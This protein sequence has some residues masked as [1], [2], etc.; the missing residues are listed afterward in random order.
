MFPVK[1]NLLPTVSRFFDDDWNSLFDWSNRNFS[2]VQSTLPSVNIVESAEEFIVEMAA[3]GMKKEDFHIELNNNVLSISCE[4][5]NEKKEK[6]DENY[7]RREFSYQNFQR[8][9]NLNHRVVDDARINAIYKDGIL[10]LSL[11]KK[12]EAKT[13]P[14]RQIKIS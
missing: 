10:K 14:A 8:T 13:K 3:P 12:E 5:K 7:Y 1:S 11:P 9:F 4:S 2:S 6:E